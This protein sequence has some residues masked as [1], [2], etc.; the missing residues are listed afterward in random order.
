MDDESSGLRIA[1]FLSLVAG[2]FTAKTVVSDFPSNG[3]ASTDPRSVPGGPASRD[4]GPGPP[5]GLGTWAGNESTPPSPSCPA[6]TRDSRRSAFQPVVSRRRRFPILWLRVA[7][8]TARN[9]RSRLL[10]VSG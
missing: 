7:S 1:T 3:H 2:A 6:L 10:C 8:S 4:S 9:T 5:R